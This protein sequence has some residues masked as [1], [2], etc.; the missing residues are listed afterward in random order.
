MEL[1]FDHSIAWKV[2]HPPNVFSF[3]LHFR[4]GFAMTKV[5]HTG[6]PKTPWDRHTGGELDVQLEQES[7]V[8]RLPPRSGLLLGHLQPGHPAKHGQHHLI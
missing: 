6:L 2:S 7:L 8:L 4:F 3:S 1:G 5:A